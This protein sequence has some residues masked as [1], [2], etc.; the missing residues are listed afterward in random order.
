[1]KRIYCIGVGQSVKSGAGRAAIISIFSDGAHF[2]GHFLAIFTVFSFGHAV[3]SEASDTSS[4][5]KAER[6]ANITSTCGDFTVYIFD[7]LF[8]SSHTGH[9]LSGRGWGGLSGGWA[10]GL[11]AV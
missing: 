3:L 9:A 1:M 11:A 6:A 10:S 5:Y 2:C 8:P 4:F 7:K